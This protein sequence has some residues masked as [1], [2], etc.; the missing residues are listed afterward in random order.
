MRSLRPCTLNIFVQ[1]TKGFRPDTF[2]FRRHV[3]M[4]RFAS[5]ALRRVQVVQTAPMLRPHPR[6]FSTD[7]DNIMSIPLDQVPDL[8]PAVRSALSL[9]NASRSQLKSFHI[10]NT[11]QKHARSE[12]DTGSPEVQIAVMTE[13]IKSLTEHLK[14][15]RK[16]RDSQRNVVRLVHKRRGMMR[17][18]LRKSP[19]RYLELVHALGLRETTVFSKDV[20]ARGA[21]NKPTP[22]LRR[23]D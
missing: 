7:R 3:R 1:N 14:V 4:L 8:H 21:K 9:D 22:M 2:C 17:Y 11:V 5:A 18:L 16:D 10:S 19:E 12:S 20:G 15:H 23:N 13:R 6:L